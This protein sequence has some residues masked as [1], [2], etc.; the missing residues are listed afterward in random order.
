MRIL[1]IS[2]RIYPDISGPAKQVY[3]LS[4]YC[5]EN[6]IEVRNIACIPK[7]KPYVKEE[8]VNNNFTIY[9][10]PFHAPGV[11][12]GLFKL[13]TFF[14]K[15]LIF[16]MIKAFQI[17]RKEKIDIIHAH[18]PPPSGF[19][20]YSIHKILKIPY[21]YT[22][23]GLE[24]PIQILEDLDINIT[25]KNSK[26]TFVVS[27]ALENHIKTK[28]KLKN[29]LWFTNGIE[30][31]N[32]FHVST[33]VEKATLI[34]KIKLNNYLT[35]EDFIISY[36]G[37]MIFHQKVRGMIDFLNGF[38][39]FLN[40]IDNEDEKRKIKLIFIGDGEYS[41]LLQEKLKEL[42]LEKNVFILGRRSD[43]REIL[44]ISDLLGLTSY[45]EGFPNVILE[46]MSS[47]IPC[48]G[49]NV[50]EIKHIIGD[51]GYIIKPGDIQDI[52]N[53]LEDFYSLTK[54]GKLE[55]M[56]KSYIQIKKQFDLKTLGKKLIN[57]YSS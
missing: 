35:K 7:N 33:E 46:A 42:Q 14:I 27:R 20:A 51:A 21:F 15:F 45:V 54:N 30:I 28:Y 1:R 3:L 22:I 34:K 5:S 37:Y 4:K 10:L 31:S 24:A 48:I 43:V 57:F 11:N 6:N 25:V 53:K 50:G 32:Y 9:Y 13:I 17:I 56:N 26:K 41:Y 55:L 8:K 16:G 52:Q 19:I 23:H 29:L 44:A 36:I 18:S 12:A 47:N 40:K 49:T 39:N 38:Y 2:T